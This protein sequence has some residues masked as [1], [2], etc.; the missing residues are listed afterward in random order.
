[1]SSTFQLELTLFSLMAA[2]S[3]PKSNSAVA[4]LNAA[5][6][7]IGRYCKQVENQVSRAAKKE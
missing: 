7:S 6:P 5:R 2:L 4:L 1:M 3:A